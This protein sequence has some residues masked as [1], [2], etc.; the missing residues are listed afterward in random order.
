MAL[1][2]VL[3][4]FALAQTFN[5][6]DVYKAMRSNGTP[7]V[8]VANQSPGSKVEVTYPNAT[9]TR[10]V[11][12]NACGLISLRDT[13]SKPLANLVSV[14]G[15]N[16]DQAAL[17]T[18]LLPR[19]IDGSLEE[20]RT[21]HFKTG[22]GEVVLVKTPNTVYQAVYSGGR[23]RKVTVNACGYA[24]VNS[25]KTLPW[26]DAANKDFEISGT[27]YNIDTLPEADPA[28]I[29]RSGQLYIPNAW[30]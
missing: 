19:C 21:D 3:S 6:N 20:A 10:R 18:Q 13:S 9:S 11:T 1:T 25:T 28:P 24:A 5:G 22:T 16:I 8:I 30:P 26:D 15:E 4:P 7:Q 17:P 29:C 27:A 14:D 12:A 23:S 2:A